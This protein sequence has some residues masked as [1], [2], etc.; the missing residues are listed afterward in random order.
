[1]KRYRQDPYLETEE[2]RKDV[3]E[4]AIIIKKYFKPNTKGY[5]M[6][7]LMMHVRR[8]IG[9][10]QPWCSRST[11]PPAMMKIG[12]KGVNK[13]FSIDFVDN[14]NYIKAF[15]AQTLLPRDV[16]NIILSLITI[17]FE[18]CGRCHKVHSVEFCEKNKRKLKTNHYTDLIETYS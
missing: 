13:R 16:I 7:P 4:N 10:E 18:D 15:A 12:Y 9:M 17:D 6:K 8:V 11:I 14:D 3:E 5:I 1:M 2:Y